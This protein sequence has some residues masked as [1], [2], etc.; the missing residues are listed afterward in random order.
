[1]KTV[2]CYISD[3]GKPASPDPS[4][5]YIYVYISYVLYILCGHPDRSFVNETFIRL[6]LG[7]W[8]MI[9]CKVCIRLIIAKQIVKAD[10][11]AAFEHVFWSECISLESL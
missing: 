4:D 1:M 5:T 10:K 9:L 8:E 11:N 6:G 3:G 7:E 2:C